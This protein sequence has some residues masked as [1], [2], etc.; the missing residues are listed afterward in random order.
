MSKE[1]PQTVEAADAPDVDLE[2]PTAVDA[3]GGLRTVDAGLGADQVVLAMDRER[4]ARIL[5]KVDWHLVPLLS[6]LYLIGYVDRSNIGNAKI[7]G[8][9]E[10]LHLEGMMYN[11]AL[12]LFFVPYALFEVPS[13]IVLKLVRPSLWISLLLFAWGLVMTMMGLVKSAQGLYVARFFLGFAE[14]GFFPA[15]T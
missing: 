8:M 12:T 14:A 13:N 15:S 1:A 7:A 11:T 9:T 5:R 10:D 4:E 2:K 6:F 3:G